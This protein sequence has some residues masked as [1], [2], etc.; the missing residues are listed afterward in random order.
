MR[1]F[2]NRINRW[3]PA[4]LCGLLLACGASTPTAPA[5]VRVV[6]TEF[7]NE[8]AALTLPA[9][10]TVTLTFKNAGQTLHDF[11]ID[12]GS[13]VP[14]PAQHAEGDHMADKPPYHVAANAGQEA[15]LSLS[16]PAGSYTFICSVSGHEQL[17]MKGTVTVQ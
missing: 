16:L 15:T 5:G 8:P 1:V 6:A 7:R 14:T 12:A 13:G 9:G 4:A 10:Q 2:F 3:M 11:T 17:G